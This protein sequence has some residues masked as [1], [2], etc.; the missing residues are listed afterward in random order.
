MRHALPISL[1][2]IIVLAGCR[3]SDAERPPLAPASVQ[4]EGADRIPSDTLA[5]Y[6]VPELFLAAPDSGR[7]DVHGVLVGVYSC[8]PCPSFGGVPAACSP[9]MGEYI[10]LAADPSESPLPFPEWSS[11]QVT[12]SVGLVRE[13]EEGQSYE[14]L[15]DVRQSSRSRPRLARLEVGQAYEVSVEV[16]SCEDC[17]GPEVGPLSHT[18]V[19]LRTV[20][21]GGR[22]RTRPPATR[23]TPE[24][25]RIPR[26]PWRRPL[27]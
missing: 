26:E 16:H 12:V 19:S 18:N 27:T 6:T 21:G 2:A 13:I 22:A 10:T 8:P 9:C 17:F 3:K 5:S 25:R 24:S 15:P 11:R 14:V 7:F 23:E 1:L 20:A 4:G